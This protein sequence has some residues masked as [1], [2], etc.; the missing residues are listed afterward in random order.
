MKRSKS[1]LSI[2]LPA[3]N[4]EGG[5]QHAVDE[6]GKVIQ[7]CNIAYEFIVIDDGSR[8]NTYS[9][10]CELIDQKNYVI[11][12]IKFSRN[13]GKEAAIL[14]GLKNAAGDIVITMDA[15]LQHPP[16][17]IPEMIQAW[18][19][20]AHI[21][22]AVKENRSQDR[23]I[24]RFRA[25]IFNGILT[26]LG[27]I[28]IRNSS[29]FK[30]LDRE[31]VDVIVHQI[32]ERIRFYRGL[33]DWIGYQQT[34]IPFTVANRNNGEGKWSTWGLIELATTAIVSFTSVPLRIITILGCIT[35]VFG[36]VV[37]IDALWGWF[38]NQ[39]VSG[40]VTIIMTLLLLGSFIMIS[41][42]I[43]GE[44]IAKI[45]DEIKARPS[46]LVESRKGFDTQ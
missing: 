1:L 41:L 12:A 17:I 30:L 37:A 31:V 18:E 4:E 25:G 28:D 16:E 29:D 10:V 38:N 11:K 8:D 34:T 20:G 13:F 32:P 3:H 42:G 35:L 40:F 39:A 15:D 46:Y 36:F 33:A 21:V 44:Y 45:Y 27:G 6:I 19:Q 9:K 26:R 5:I 22:S 7:T 43:V 2:I 23:F 24:A 14:A